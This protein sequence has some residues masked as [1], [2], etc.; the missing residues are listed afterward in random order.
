MTEGMKI[1]DARMKPP[2]RRTTQYTAKISS[3][4]YTPFI[5]GLLTLMGA[6]LLLR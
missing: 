2:K 1:T 3:I 6:S 5:S 4:Q